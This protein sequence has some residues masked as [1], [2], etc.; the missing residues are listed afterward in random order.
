MLDLD[1]CVFITYRYVYSYISQSSA[2]IRSQ[3]MVEINVKSIIRRMM[4]TAFMMSLV[5]HWI[6][7][8]QWEIK[9]TSPQ[10]LVLSESI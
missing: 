10:R 1:F 2:S 3:Q 4:P 8:Q 9:Q 7:V 5:W 6:T